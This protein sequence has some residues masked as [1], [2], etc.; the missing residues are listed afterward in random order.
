MDIASRLVI[1][2]ALI[3]LG[4]LLYWA[5]NR[6]QLRRLGRAANAPGLE[7]WQP[8]VPGIL[9]FTTPECTPCR[10]V[11]RPALQRLQAELGARLQVITVDAHAHAEVAAHWG[12]LSVPTTFV[13]DGHGQPRHIN[14]G[15]TN[16]AKLKQ[17]LEGRRKEQTGS[18]DALFASGD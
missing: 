8:G 14:H 12:V 9:Y 13:L 11:Q 6:W 18:K 16:A 1:A 5:W 10:T 7:A 17:Q 3:A 4:V 15:V 2:L